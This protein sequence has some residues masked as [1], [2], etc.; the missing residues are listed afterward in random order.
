MPTSQRRAVPELPV[1]EIGQLFNATDRAPLRER[2]LGPQAVAH[3]LDWGC[4][5]PAGPP[6]E[7]ILHD[8]WPMQAEAR[9]RDRL[10]ASD[11]R[12]DGAPPA[13]QG[14]AA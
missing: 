13:T 5:F 10:A 2:D 8:G 11:V 6:L 9:L 7:I 1:G 4:E 14:A 12:V 3:N